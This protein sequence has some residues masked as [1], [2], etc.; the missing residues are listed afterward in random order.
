MASA[1]K[2]SDGGAVKSNKVASK[3]A[4]MVAPKQSCIR[5][6]KAVYATECEKSAKGDA[7][8]RQCFSCAEPTCRQKLNHR[9]ARTNP[10]DPEI[11]C[12]GHV[13][14][15]AAGN[16]GPDA[17]NMMRLK[18]YSDMQKKLNKKATL[19][20]AKYDLSSYGIQGDI[21]SQ[22]LVKDKNE[23]K[24]DS[25]S[26]HHFPAVLM[27]AN[28][29]YQNELRDRQALLEQQ[30]K[31]EEDALFKKF[32]AERREA[33][34]EAS[35]ETELEWESKLKGIIAMLEKNNIDETEFEKR[36]AEARKDYE[37]RKSQI[38]RNKTIRVAQKQQRETSALVDRQGDEM[39]K[40]IKDQK[41]ILAKDMQEQLEDAKNN[42]TGD[43]KD[44]KREAA[45]WLDGLGEES[46]NIE[47][48]V[49]GI[50]GTTEAPPPRATHNPKTEIMPDEGDDFFNEVFDNH[51]ATVAE[52]EQ[53]SFTELVHILTGPFMDDLS[54][55]RA[56]YRW[57][58]YKDLNK[59]DFCEGGLDSPMGL[60]RGIKYGTETYH[61][62]FKRLCSYA[63]LHCTEVNGKSK[64]VGYEPGMKFDGNAFRNTWNAVLIDGEWRLV[65][66][67]WGARFMVIN[68]D[69]DSKSQDSEDK[70]N[71]KYQYDEHYFLTDP[72]DF[73]KE[74]FPNKPEWQLLESPL[75]LEQFEKQPLIRSIFF[76]LGL[77]FKQEYEA[78]LDASETGGVDVR[79]MVPQQIA[80]DTAFLYQLRFID[81]ARARD[82][83]Y[84]GV[85][86]DRFVYQSMDENEV[87]YSVHV[88]TNGEYYL[89]IFASKMDT[90][91]QGQL[92]SMDGVKLK[93]V[94]KFKITCSGREEKMFPLPPC[95]PGEW[96]PTK[97]SRQFGMRPMSHPKG[98][99]IAENNLKDFVD[100]QFDDEHLRVKVGFPVEGQYGLDIYA[101]PKNAPGDQPLAHACKYLVNV[102]NVQ[103]IVDLGLA[104]LSTALNAC[105]GNWGALPDIN[106]YSMA[107]QS[108]ANWK[109]K[110][111]SPLTVIYFKVPHNVVLTAHL[112]KEPDENYHEHLQI[113]REG[114]ET[115]RITVNGLRENGNYMLMMF[116]RFHSD[117]STEY[118]NVF[119]YLVRFGPESQQKQELSA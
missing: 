50:V 64:S 70:K 53:T 8:H 10:G 5:C 44:E 108:H 39:L 105:M 6:G 91:K 27:D 60:M 80:R 17:M 96:G 29:Q 114:H 118:N 24:L 45:E 79:I 63:G 7:F 95:A 109:V 75:T 16:I 82:V 13:P 54:K 34:T 66:C 78:V 28:E 26:E 83:E 31:A 119:N 113:Q 21:Q 100:A 86:L 14:K 65:Q 52:N 51:V 58:T 25:L 3:F 92:T 62:L 49:T 68:K 43:T 42:A 93:C 11:Y 47:E 77:K 18:Q 81:K 94:C 46:M 85:K 33:A 97:A 101:K 61:T 4:S 55:A 69:K 73:V 12:R 104:Q 111:S 115:M 89:Q 40:L 112:V 1:E 36:K 23:N 56:I 57:I 88:P 59:I 32:E 98:V 22:S 48:V 87:I 37:L 72:E 35:K 117:D 2:K 102:T 84:R 110:S 103:N 15:M 74:F 90:T 76:H 38:L 30:Q 71:I 99:L 106:K 41:E 67:N 107:P 116:A 19:K 9:N 20:A